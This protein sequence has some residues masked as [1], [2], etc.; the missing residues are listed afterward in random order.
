MLLPA[1]HGRA[2]VAAVAVVAMPT[3]HGCPVVAGMAQHGH[4]RAAQH[5][6]PVGATQHRGAVAGPQHRQAVVGNRQRGIT[7]HRG[8]AAG[9]ASHSIAKHRLPKMA[10]GIAA[11]ML[12]TRMRGAVAGSSA[13]A[14]Q[15]QCGGQVSRLGGLPAGQ[16]CQA[17]AAVLR[18]TAGCNWGRFAATARGS[19]DAA[20]KHVLRERT[21][22]EFAQSVAS[23][24][25]QG[26]TVQ[27][28]RSA[29]YGKGLVVVV[30]STPPATS[31]GTLHKLTR[32][33]LRL[34]L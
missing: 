14:G 9:T 7:K 23:A 31:P 4:A 25:M 10:G 22:G 33:A 16:V 15:L 18:G 20:G 21:W 26:T 29:R 3:Q 2:I 6:R 13:A 12:A 34:K 17:H 8:A 11:L 28:A 24:L 5:G 1:Q 30:S 27:P 19:V 32:K